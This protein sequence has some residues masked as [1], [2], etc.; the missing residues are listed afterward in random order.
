VSAGGPTQRWVRSQMSNAP[1]PVQ[2]VASRDDFTERG[3]VSRSTLIAT[4]AL[5]LS[6]G[7]A[8]RKAPA[9][10]RPALVWLRLHRA[11]PYR[12]LAVGRT[13]DRSH[14]PAFP[15]L[16]HNETLQYRAAWCSRNQTLPLLHASVF[17]VAQPSRM[18]VKRASSP[19]LH[20]RRRDADRTRRRGRLR[21]G[22]LR[23]AL[24]TY[25]SVARA[26]TALNRYS[27]SAGGVPGR[28]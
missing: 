16:W 17:S 10:H 1:G 26:T 8:A 14:A 20:D 19:Y 6:K 24:N 27:G 3:S 15:N 11:G 2:S 18:R 7:G 28:Q 21:Y 23:S 25:L 5:D 22:S 4:D 12:R 9:C 13:W